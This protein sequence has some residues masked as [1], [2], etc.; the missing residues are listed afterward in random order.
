MS[1]HEMLNEEYSKIVVFQHIRENKQI[2]SEDKVIG[3]V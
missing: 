3:L 2:G 1:V